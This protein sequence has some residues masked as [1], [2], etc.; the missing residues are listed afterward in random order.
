MIRVTIIVP[1]TKGRAWGRRGMTQGSLT[2]ISGSG[3]GGGGVVYGVPPTPKPARLSSFLIILSSFF[4][5]GCH[6]EEQIS[7]D[8]C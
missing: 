5:F 8:P 4:S 1:S 7:R 3:G 2:V 6:L